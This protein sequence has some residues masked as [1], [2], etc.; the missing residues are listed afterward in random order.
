MTRPRRAL[1]IATLLAATAGGVA[2]CGEE[3]DLASRLS[4]RSAA[5][6]F[7]ERCSG[8]HTL[9]VA[10]TQGSTTNVRTREYKDGPNFDQRHE[11]VT[12]VLYAIRN[13]GFSS[14]PMPQNIVTGA[15]A[16]AL[17][18]FVSENSKPDTSGG[19]G[20][21]LPRGL[22]ARS[23]EHLP[24][25]GAGAGGSGTSARRVGRAADGRR[26]RCA[27]SSTRCSPSSRA[28]RPRATPAPSAIGEAKRTGGDA[29]RGDR[30]DAGRER[31]RAR[32][33]RRR[34]RGWTTELTALQATL[35]N[36]PDPSAADA[37]DTL[38][39]VGEKRA[40]GR[41]HLELAGAMIDMEAG[42]KVSGLAVRVPEGRPGLP[43]VGACALGA[44]SCCARTGSS[45]SSRRCWSRRRRCSAPASCPTPS[46]RSTAWP[47]I[48]CS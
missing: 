27:R 41:D 18:K 8:C 21:G 7:D 37:D 48:R 33:S 26:S 45:R 4:E 20:A 39:E 31:A 19:S 14:G 34:W 6:L 11:S 38:R 36:P 42:S 15:E 1:L 29:S 13:G 28:P 30:G 17:A 46:S 35:P 24:R 25:P 23:T 47:T 12:C 43:G 2:A 44:W 9:S 22:D 5:A 16:E 10:G 32:S 40:A 3:G